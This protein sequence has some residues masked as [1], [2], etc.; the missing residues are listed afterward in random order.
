MTEPAVPCNRLSVMGGQG[1][2]HIRI[3]EVD[4][5]AREMDWMAD[6][7]RGAA[8]LVTPG[9]EGLQDMR[10]MKAI[11]DSVAAGGATIPTDWGY[12]RAYDPAA[13]VDVPRPA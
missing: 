6:V 5:F 3:Q 7:A 9:E 13:V 8:P 1:D 2:P 12:R 11:M 4:H 10:L